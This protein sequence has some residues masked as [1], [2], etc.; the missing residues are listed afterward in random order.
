MSHP[1]LREQCRTLVLQLLRAPA[2]PTQPIPRH[3]A[4]PHARL[5]DH[6]LTTAALVCC[7]CPDHP[8][9]DLLR[10]AALTHDLAPDRRAAALGSVAAQVQPWLDHLAAQ[11]AQ[12]D[13]DE[14]PPLAPDLDP[15]TRGLLLAHLAASRPAASSRRSAVAAHPLAAAGPVDLVYGG[16]TRVKNYVFESARLPE[17]RGASVLLDHLNRLDLPAFWGQTPPVNLDLLEP[18][19]AA[20]PDETLASAQQARYTAARAWFTAQTGRAPLDAPECVLYASGGN[21]LALA[22]A[23][24]GPALAAAIEQRYTAETFTAGSV[25]VSRSVS[26]LELQYGSAPQ[27]SQPADIAQMAASSPAAERL[28]RQSLGATNGDLAAAFAEHKGFGELVT[29]LANQANQRRASDG[30]DSGTPRYASLIELTSFARKCTSCD[31]RPAVAAIADER[32]QFFCQPCLT[33]RWF[34]S[35]AKQRDRPDLRYNPDI[36]N[37]AWVR[38]WDTWLETSAAALGQPRIIAQTTRDLQELGAAA[39][40]SAR[41][42]VGLIYAD[43]N[44]VASHVARLTTVSAY[45]TFARSM[46]TANE[47]TV[48][49]ALLDTLRPGRDGVWPFEII[50]IGGDDVL[51]FVPAD[52]A[53]PLAHRIAQDFTTAMQPRGITLSVGVLLMPDTTP[54]RFAV[55]LAEQLLT[56]AKA[57]SKQQTTGPQPPTLDFMALKEVTMVAETITDYRAAALRRP[58]QTARARADR[59]ETLSL[60]QRPYHLDELATLLNACRMLQQARFPRSQLYQLRQIIEQGQVLQS[61]I[62]YHYYVGRGQRR[63][64][65]GES[66]AYTQFATRMAALCGERAWLPWRITV[67]AAQADRPARTRYDTPLLDLIE[68]APFVSDATAEIAHEL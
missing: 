9:R 11:G 52:Q 46:I 61:V 55:D 27:A 22:P 34:G 28:I 57:H 49:Q 16:A 58:V 56:S 24:Y 26:L 66:D 60:T 3:A 67:Q 53:L 35:W 15:G 17:I 64:R 47:R 45:R 50:T 37:L 36:P 14:V 8:R 1:D 2:D 42:Y 18:P 62:D 20:V 65:S 59:T 44:N 33:K 31:E 38:P 5:D 63:T 39:R 13:R 6:L 4:E 48:A 30:R 40:G 23:G 7:L 29:L 41:G 43:G 51:L 25:A 19:P 68:L 10:L 12:L 54:V 21:L 32:Q